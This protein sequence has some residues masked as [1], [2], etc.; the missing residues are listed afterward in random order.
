VAYADKKLAGLTANNPDL[1][2]FLKRNGRIV[3]YQG[4]ADPVVP[5]EDGIR[6]YESVRQTMGAAKTDGFFRLFMAPGMGHCGGGPG[7]S[8]FDSLA[9][10]DLW[11]T[12]GVAPE[13]MIAAHYN[14]TAM[15]RSR[16]L[17]PYPQ[18]ARWK[19]SGSTD[20]AASF[21]CVPPGRR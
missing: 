16:P 17:C 18:V 4:W 11:V 21:T 7:P 12:G 10:L 19:G 13:L 5:P 1:T 15:D 20:N 2:P 9:T 8:Y 3:M 14:G 6:Y